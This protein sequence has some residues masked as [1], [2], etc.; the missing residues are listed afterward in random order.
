ME[1]V[2][3]AQVVGFDTVVEAIAGIAFT[4]TLIGADAADVQPFC[5]TVKL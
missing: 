1:P 4:T 3:V 2:D 5:V